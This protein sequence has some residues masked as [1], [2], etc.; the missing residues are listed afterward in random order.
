MNAFFNFVLLG[1]HAP[2]GDSI[3]HKQNSVL[4]EHAPFGDSI[5][6]KQNSVQIPTRQ[7]H[8]QGNSEC[9]LNLMN[10]ETYQA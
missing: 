6:H 1:E 8:A 3:P 4:G 9:N 5:P 10:G 2:F 7:P